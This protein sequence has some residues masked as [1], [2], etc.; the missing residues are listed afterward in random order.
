[1]TPSVWGAGPALFQPATQKAYSIGELLMFSVSQIN[2][3]NGSRRHNSF[4]KTI[5]SSCFI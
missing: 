2:G 4:N 3:E 1:M 5:L